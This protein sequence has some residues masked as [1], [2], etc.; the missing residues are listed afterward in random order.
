MNE[1]E[2]NNLVTLLV[3]VLSPIVVKYGISENVLAQLLPAVAAMGW[4]V[5]SHWN[6]TKVPETA[7]VTPAAP[8]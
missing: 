8:K 3:A 7:T 4:G 5:W 6:M 1:S 2:I